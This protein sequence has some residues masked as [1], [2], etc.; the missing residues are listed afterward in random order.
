MHLL[1][2]SSLSA[3]TIT[4]AIAAA[5]GQARHAPTAPVSRALLRGEDAGG[6]AGGAGGQQV[7]LHAAAPAV[8][9]GTP[10]SS[11][12]TGATVQILKA[13]PAAT[14]PVSQA[15]LRGEG[16]GG[17]AGGAGGNLVGLHAATP[18]VNVGTPNSS[19]AT[20]ATVQ[21]LKASASIAA[22]SKVNAT[23]GAHLAGVMDADASEAE[24][25][26]APLARE[27][28]ED[29]R[30]PGS[31]PTLLELARSDPPGLRRRG[32]AR[33]REGTGSII[34]EFTFE[35]NLD[36]AFT[37]L[38]KPDF[39]EG[40]EGKAIYLNKPSE[41]FLDVTT[42]LARFKS[43]NSFLEFQ[44][45]RRKMAAFSLMFDIRLY[46]ELPK[47][48]VTVFQFVKVKPE[49]EINEL[50][51]FRVDSGRLLLGDELLT[52][53]APSE[54]VH[55]GLTSSMPCDNGPLKVFVDGSLRVD[56]KDGGF[57][58]CGLTP[59]VNL[60]CWARGAQCS[61]KVP[62]LLDNLWF[63]QDYITRNTV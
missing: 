40:K 58:V 12:A 31:W 2:H 44:K 39:T 5:F 19:A 28:L 63:I 45:V 54:W 53:L 1:M 56:K 48:A 6:D 32:G 37:G 16:A 51:Q 14:A 30:P 27:F 17:D 26:E 36:G 24:A 7:G 57:N 62:L 59:L 21:I 49:F 33:R 46:P 23:V 34:R 55:I 50:L 15:L 47:D 11:A 20:G 13:R 10:N 60:D 41:Q 42:S 52:G 61:A 29:P 35:D 18:A 22:A 43:E 9:V 38:W 25:S 4:L 8:T 3:L